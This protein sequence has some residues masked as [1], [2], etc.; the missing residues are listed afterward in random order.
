MV[1]QVVQVQI[2]SVEQVEVE[3]VI[4][5]L[6]QCFRRNIWK[7]WNWRFRVYFWWNRCFGFN[8]NG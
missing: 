3:L 7:W 1:A 4:Q 5:V 2:R 6:V 8:L